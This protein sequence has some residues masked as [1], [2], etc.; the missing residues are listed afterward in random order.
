MKIILNTES[1]GEISNDEHQL[2][3]GLSKEITRILKQEYKQKCEVLYIRIICVNDSFKELIYAR[4]IRYCRKVPEICWELDA[5][6]KEFKTL[7]QQPSL[8]KN[9]IKERFINEISS[10]K[11]FKN[12]FS[13]EFIDD[14]TK[15]LLDTRGH[16]GDD[17]LN[18]F[19]S[20]GYSK[21]QALE[22]LTGLAAKLISN[23]TNAL[24]HTDVDEAM[25]AYAWEKPEK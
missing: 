20:A 5:D 21:R 3:V 23:F 14:F 22:V 17:K 4:P 10:N 15:A 18:A 13:I 12:S 19:L 24:T 25:K 9:F 8:V 16:I 11:R 6:L 2:I 7:I 1:S